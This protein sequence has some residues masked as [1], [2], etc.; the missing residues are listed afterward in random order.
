MINSFRESLSDADRLRQLYAHCVD[1]LKLPGDYSD[2]LRMSL[3]YC[4]SALD[5]LMHDVILHEMV[6]I[7]V[8]RRSPTPKYL[9]EALTIENHLLLSNATVPPAEII[10]ENILRRKLGYQSFMD[11]AKLADGLSL[12]WEEPHKWKV[13]AHELG[14]DEN[15]IKTELKNMVKRRSAIVHEADRD[16]STMEK[17]PIEPSD[18]ERVHRFISAI[19]ETVYKFVCARPQT[20][21]QG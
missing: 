3:V 1:H 2:L 12:V 6:E 13:I 8:G 11:P 9:S 16:P 19:G 18:A 17:F 15:N 7:Y 14:R 20:T 4:L 10:F 5:K 21:M